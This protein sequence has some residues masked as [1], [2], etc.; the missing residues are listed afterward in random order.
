MNIWKNYL[1]TL[2]NFSRVNM[3]DTIIR[4]SNYSQY[5]GYYN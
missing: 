2:T 3:E 1:A 5:G 4:N